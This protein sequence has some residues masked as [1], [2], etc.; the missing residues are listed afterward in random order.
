MK[1]FTYRKKS[2]RVLRFLNQE[3]F[4]ISVSAL[5]VPAAKNGGT[6]SPARVVRLLPRNAKTAAKMVALGWSIQ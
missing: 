5:T 2:A 3:P 1:G 4:I 6:P